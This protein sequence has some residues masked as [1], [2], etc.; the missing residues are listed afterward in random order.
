[1]KSIGLFD[2]T[3][4][5]SETAVAG[6]NS[7]CIEWDRS[8]P[9]ENDIIFFT[10][11]EALRLQDTYCGSSIKVAWL[12]ESQSI[13]PYLY[14][15]LDAFSKF[16]M[17]FTHSS[18]LLATLKNAFFAPGGGVWIGGSHAGGE[19]AISQKSQMCSMIS[20]YKVSAPLHRRRLAYALAIRMFT[21]TRV[22]VFLG[23]KKPFSA[24][25]TGKYAFN[26]C[27]ENY[28]DE[29]YFT[30]RLL[31]CFATGTVPIY[32]GS[33]Q[34]PETFAEQGVL[35]FRNFRELLELVPSLSTEM[36]ERLLP[37]V[38]H[39]FEAVQEF[40]SLEDYIWLNY[41]EQFMSRMSQ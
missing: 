24:P 15:D 2:K 21:P 32:L 20:S 17:V 23:S 40:F 18:H 6:V 5:H 10:D 41:R 34:L 14:E 4:A 26:I 31:N 19:I 9:L 7:R 30:E 36:Y 29:M 8:S 25:A 11:D 3:F 37:F 1:M 13:K 16:D 39:N 33:R 35:R 22:K 12:I 28:I 38:K 27:V